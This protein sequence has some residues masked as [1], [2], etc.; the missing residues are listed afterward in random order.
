MVCR[1][2][3]AGAKVKAAQIIF[4]NTCMQHTGS[5]HFLCHTTL[6]GARPRKFGDTKAAEEA[7]HMPSNKMVLQ[8][9]GR[10]RYPALQLMHR[11]LSEL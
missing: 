8:S 1:G 2:G 5:S 11:Q 3:S 10:P 4:C 9:H 6:T 7:H